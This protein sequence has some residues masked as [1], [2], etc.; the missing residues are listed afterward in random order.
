MTILHMLLSTQDSSENNKD[1]YIITMSQQCFGISVVLSYRAEI[2]QLLTSGGPHIIQYL[3]QWAIVP[4]NNFDNY[5]YIE[6]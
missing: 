6:A 1:F 2:Y 3:P 4:N 5:G